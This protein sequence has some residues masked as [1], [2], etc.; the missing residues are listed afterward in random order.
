M[1]SR[2]SSKN[3]NDYGRGG[4]VNNGYAPNYGHGQQK[5]G[6]YNKY[7]QGSQ[8]FSYTLK[9][10]YTRVVVIHLRIPFDQDCFLVQKI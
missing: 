3:S 5:Y 7:N 1:P 9:F 6:S 2:K 8:R 10:I 4:Y